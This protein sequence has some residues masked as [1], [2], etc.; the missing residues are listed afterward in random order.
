MRKRCEKGAKEWGIGYPKYNWCHPSPK[1]YANFVWLLQPFFLF[2]NQK[3]I[4]C[5]GISLRIAF[6]AH[7]VFGHSHSY[8][9]KL[10][11]N[12]GQIL[13]TLQPVHDQVARISCFKG[14]FFNWPPQVE[15]FWNSRYGFMKWSVFAASGYASYISNLY[16]SITLYTAD[17]V[18]I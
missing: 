9:G 7:I 5:F 12:I 15:N 11:V 13:F 1:T 10:C 3:K 14:A 6:K 17:G 16:L 18:S 4:C 2:E 8:M